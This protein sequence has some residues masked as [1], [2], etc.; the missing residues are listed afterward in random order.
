MKIRLLA[1]GNKMPDWVNAGFQDYQ[2]RLSL[3]SFE[4]IE[5]PPVKRTKTL[6]ADKICTLE[7]QKILQKIPDNAWVVALEV[8]GKQLSTEQLAKQL[9]Q[10]QQST[11]QLVF[12]IGG[13]DGLS[14]EV[15]Q[16][17]NQYWSLSKLT[18]PHPLAR[19][20]MVEQIYR[21]WTINQNHPYHRAG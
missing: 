19:L 16:R 20:L 10:W 5:I 2:K 1:V 4:L 9:Q 18:F 6:S 7:G 12:V 21:A 13:A 14:A 8:T 15:L 11:A 3:F 17:A